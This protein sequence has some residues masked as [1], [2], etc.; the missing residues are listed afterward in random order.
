MCI[1]GTLIYVETY[2]WYQQNGMDSEPFNIK[3][4][5]RLIVTTENE[6]LWVGEMLESIWP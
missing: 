4:L 2:I 5:A 3:F 6:A 1:D